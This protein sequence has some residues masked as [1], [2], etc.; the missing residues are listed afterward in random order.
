MK[1]HF[2]A[3]MQVHHFARKHPYCTRS[4]GDHMPHWKFTMTIQPHSFLICFAFKNYD[5]LTTTCIN[6]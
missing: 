2:T 6:I 1:P 5:T 3:H 4:K